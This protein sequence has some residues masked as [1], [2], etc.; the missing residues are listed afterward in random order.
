MLLAACSATLAVGITAQDEALPRVDAFTTAA[1]ALVQANAEA[2]ALSF[3]ASGR[4]RIEYFPA[5]S[6]RKVEGSRL[7]AMSDAARRANQGV[8]RSVLSESGYLRVNAIRGLEDELAR[9]EPGNARVRRSDAYLAKVYGNPTGS[10]P[11]S[12]Q[13]EGH[14]LSVNAT[15]VDGQLRGTPLFLGSNP[16]E[17]RSGTN[18][19][20]RVLAQQQDLARDLFESLTD[21]QKAQVLIVES[22]SIGPGGLT[23]V[24]ELRGVSA[25][26]MS[27]AQLMTLRALVRSYTEHLHPTLATEE[28]E[29]IESSGWSKVRFS[30]RGGTKVGEAHSYRIQGPTV[31]IDFDM[32]RDD[33]SK[34]ANH[35]H[36]L[37]RDPERDFGL[38]LIRARSSR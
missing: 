10:D 23:E 14:H 27:G 7:D 30:W 25:S 11:W 17:V 37:W 28:L 13:L 15:M 1:Q 8:L 20:V 35:V 36:C 24:P 31:L 4:E 29:R 26:D 9:L 6:R 33:P 19:G 5:V 2:A 38:D 32:I 3:D 22:G 21:K 18:A 34:P 12:Y 16:A